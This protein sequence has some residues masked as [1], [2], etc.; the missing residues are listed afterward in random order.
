MAGHFVKGVGFGLNYK[1]AT[2]MNKGINM[3]L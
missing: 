3:T 1:F 2:P